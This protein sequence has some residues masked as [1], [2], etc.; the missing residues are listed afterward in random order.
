[1]MG[2]DLVIF[3]WW[4]EYHANP[5]IKNL[6]ANSLDQITWFCY[7]KFLQKSFDFV[8]SFFVW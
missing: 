8:N 1:M 4:G 3:Y 2:W 7:M 5:E 6:M